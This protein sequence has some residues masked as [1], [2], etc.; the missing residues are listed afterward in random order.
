LTVPD[1]PSDQDLTAR[2][3]KGDQAAF[4]TLMQRHKGWL[5][6][7][8][9]RYVGEAEEAYDVVQESF[10]SAWIALSRYDPHRPFDVWLRR[11]ALNKCRD[12]ARKAAV[13]RVLFGVAGAPESRPES[14]DPAV[15]PDAAAASRR[16]LARLE[17]AIATLPRGLKEPLVLTALEGLS[18]K[19]AG[20][21]LGMNAKAVETR[22]YRA[23][24][25]L[26]Q[27]LEREDLDDIAEQGL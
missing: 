21:V 7:F 11:I 20:D 6:R 2:A 19:E 16:A 26:A 27:L 15:G 23:R 5:F 12:R 13:R 4:A 17:A 24:K 22:V 3:V 25:Q 10:A 18:H 9:R 8:V 14:P 1:E